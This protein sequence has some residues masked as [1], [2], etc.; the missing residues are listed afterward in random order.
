MSRRALIL[1]SSSVYRRE[2]MQRLGLSFQSVSPDVDETPHTVETPAVTAMR[3]A[4]AKA[5]AVA[6]AYPEALIIGSDQLADLD[7]TALGKPGNHAN[8]L[9]QLQA[10]RGRRVVFHTALCL[11]DAASGRHQLENVPTSVLFRHLDDAMIERYLQREQ[12]YDCAGSAKVET[13]GVALV[14]AIES[15]DPTALIGLPLITLVTLL[16]REGVAV[17]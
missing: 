12:P 4:L 9:R 16:Q 8:A 17:I 7:G 3:L 5:R 13:L 1:A 15:S 2:L 6:T 14:S 11:L 10:M